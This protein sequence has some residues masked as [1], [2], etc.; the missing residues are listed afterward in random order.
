MTLIFKITF[1]AVLATLLTLSSRAAAQDTLLPDMEKSCEGVEMTNGLLISLS[2]QFFAGRAFAKPHPGN[3]RLRIYEQKASREI[4]FQVVMRPD[5]VGTFALY[6]PSAAAFVNI[7][8]NGQVFADV[9]PE[10]A[11][12][13]EFDKSEHEG[14]SRLRKVGSDAHIGVA[15]GPK[16][17]LKASG[18]PAEVVDFCI[19]PV[20][21]N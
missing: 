17:W 21:I 3:S 19:L 8:R 5:S 12:L 15:T 18:D 6:S 10:R 20:R 11:T 1:F 16:P 13:F 7:P 2:P 4:V 14:Y 9:K